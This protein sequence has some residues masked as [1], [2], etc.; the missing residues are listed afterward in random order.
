MDIKIFISC[1]AVANPSTR[2]ENLFT[3]SVQHKLRKKSTIKLSTSSS[4]FM[5]RRVW[6]Q[7]IGFVCILYVLFLLFFNL[8]MILKFHTTLLY[9]NSQGRSKDVI[10][11]SK[12]SKLLCFRESCSRKSL[13]SSELRRRLLIF[14][15]NL[16]DSTCFPHLFI[17]EVSLYGGPW[18]KVNTVGS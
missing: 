18:L 5:C 11:S 13:F 15:H 8:R 7:K 10:F 16:T 3:Y 12:Q 4:L 1:L 17:V 14:S 6:Y 2:I 9:M